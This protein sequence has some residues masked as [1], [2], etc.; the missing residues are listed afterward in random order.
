MLILDVA[1]RGLVGDLGGFYGFTERIVLQVCIQSKKL[2]TLGA[3]LPRI[4][5]LGFP[6][7]CLSLRQIAGVV[8]I[9]SLLTL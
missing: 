4:S 2:V 1:G 6:V 8:S 9:M 3:R 5:G 7:Q